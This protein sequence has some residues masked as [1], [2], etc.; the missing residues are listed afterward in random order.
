MRA[1]PVRRTINF[2]NFRNFAVFALA[3]GATHYMPT[4][5]MYKL[6]TKIQAE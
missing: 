2:R 5:Y 3:A 6:D 4:R 1:N